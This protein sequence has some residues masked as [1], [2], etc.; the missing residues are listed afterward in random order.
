[1]VVQW[2]KAGRPL[3]ETVN[4]PF[5]PWAKTVGGILLVNGFP[6][7]LANYRHRKTADDP[8]RHG[9][10]ILGAARPDAWLKPD[11]WAR[12]AVQLGVDK[13]VIPVADRG[14]EAGNARGIGVM[15][16]AHRDETFDGENETHK[17]RL[18]IEK[19]RRR[20]DGGPAHVRYRFSV[21]HQEEIPTDDEA[22]KAKPTS[23]PRTKNEKR[24]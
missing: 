8:V 24:R 17:L 1:M 3:D 19:A 5:T 18:K 21:L 16:Y 6:S 13:S 22:D 14:N 4:H 9:L 11:E 7:F 2:N 23:R 20:W 10:A 12:L 15:F